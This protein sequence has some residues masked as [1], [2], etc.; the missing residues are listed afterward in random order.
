MNN[1]INFI[2]RIKRYE[3]E[4]HYNAVATFTSIAKATIFNMKAVKAMDIVCLMVYERYKGGKIKGK[5]LYSV[6]LTP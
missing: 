6:G 3:H 2:E 5:G 4:V 1:E